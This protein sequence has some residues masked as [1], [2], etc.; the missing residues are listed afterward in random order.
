MPNISRIFQRIIR[1]YRKIADESE[2]EM[3]HQL[4]SER[5]SDTLRSYYTNQ[6]M[7]LQFQSKWLIATVRVFSEIFDGMEQKLEKIERA[8][9]I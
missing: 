5:K 9:N 3:L 7:S 1:E 4:I 6:R 8:M 2:R